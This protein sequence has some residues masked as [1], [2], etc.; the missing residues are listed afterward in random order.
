MEAASSAKLGGL[1]KPGTSGMTESFRCGE[2][3]LFD[4]SP[5]AGLGTW[6]DLSSSAKAK[7]SPFESQDG[8]SEEDSPNSCKLELKENFESGSNVLTPAEVKLKAEE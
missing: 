4:G 8:G 6:P 7:M 5:G 2:W 1:E 3:R